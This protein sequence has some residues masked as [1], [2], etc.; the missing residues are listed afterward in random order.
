MTPPPEPR[1]EVARIIDDYNWQLC[2]EEAD[3]AIAATLAWVE[4]E[5]K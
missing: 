1:E 5:K 4:R 3:A 2:L